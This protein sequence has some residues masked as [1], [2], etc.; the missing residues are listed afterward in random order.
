[1]ERRADIAP[2]RVRFDGRDDHDYSRPCS[3]CLRFL[4]AWPPRD[5]P[6]TGPIKR[7]SRREMQQLWRPSGTSV[8]RDGT[9]ALQ[10]LS[11]GYAFGLGVSQNCTFN[12]MVSH[13]GGLP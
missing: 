2:W 5:G 1:M 12:Y 9:G 11:G 10:L 13:S 8:T 6:E 7:A 4:D 3:L